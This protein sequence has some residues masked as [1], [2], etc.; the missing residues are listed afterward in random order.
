MIKKDLNASLVTKVKFW[1]HRTTSPFRG[2]DFVPFACGE[3]VG[4]KYLRSVKRP[5]QAKLREL[6]AT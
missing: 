4:G 6:C 1:L 2:Y 5:N 3:A